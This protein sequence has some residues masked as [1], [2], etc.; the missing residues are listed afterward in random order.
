MQKLTL[1]TKI[2]ADPVTTLVGVM[3]FSGTEAGEAKGLKLNLKPVLMLLVQQFLQ[4]KQMP[5]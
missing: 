5:L 3:D 1:L 4:E 2:G